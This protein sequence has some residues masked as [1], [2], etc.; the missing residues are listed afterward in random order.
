MCGPEAEARERCDSKQA[1][2]AD[3]RE[4]LT[5]GWQF[6][7]AVAAEL[8]LQAVRGPVGGRMRA[9][10]DVVCGGIVGA[11][12]AGRSLHAGVG[13]VRC[14]ILLAWPGVGAERAAAQDTGE[15]A[16]VQWRVCLLLAARYAVVCNGPSA[17]CDVLVR[18]ERSCRC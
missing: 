18:I 2:C 3:F 13:A 15:R 5:A 4:L 1:H 10:R 11:L 17:T 7:Y 8:G 14:G 6:S 12:L 16:A 9:A